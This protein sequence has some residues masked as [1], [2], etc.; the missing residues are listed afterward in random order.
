[1][2]ELERLLTEEQRKSE[3][4][5]FSI[6]EAVCGGGDQSVSTLRVSDDRYM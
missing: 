2:A 1:M 5:Q 3:D 4:L 6:D